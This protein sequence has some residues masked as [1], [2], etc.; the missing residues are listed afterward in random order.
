[1]FFLM[2]GGAISWFSKTQAIV[3]L[4]N[5]SHLVRPLRSR[6]AKKI[7]NWPGSSSKWST[8]L[9]EDNQGAVAIA[10]NGISY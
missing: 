7:H 1:M 9:I 2:T 6:L 3:V 10:R 4:P 8:M 5:M